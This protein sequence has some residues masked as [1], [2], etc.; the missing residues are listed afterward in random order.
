M[1]GKSSEIKNDTKILMT[2]APSD[3]L[4]MEKKRTVSS[5]LATRVKPEI[6]Q[7]SIIINEMLVHETL[8]IERV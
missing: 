5:R 4:I 1:H 3:R 7:L 6:N 8:V 2:V